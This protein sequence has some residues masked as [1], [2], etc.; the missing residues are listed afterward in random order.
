MVINREVTSAGSVEIIRR[1][2]DPRYYLARQSPAVVPWADPKQ[3]PLKRT[4][5]INRTRNLALSEN[6]A[7]HE[8]LGQ[9]QGEKY[10]SFRI[11][12]LGIII[13]AP[14]KKMGKKLHWGT[15]AKLSLPLTGRLAV[16][17][18]SFALWTSISRRSSN[19]SL[20]RR[21]KITS[22]YERLLRWIPFLGYHFSVF[23]ESLCSFQS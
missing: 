21:I 4:R 19:M 3:M 23:L 1:Y 7:Y 20:R 22:V 2:K 15:F 11:W 10:N 18:F 14:H 17:H 9:R 8:F 5:P 13:Y 16:R 6:E 12:F